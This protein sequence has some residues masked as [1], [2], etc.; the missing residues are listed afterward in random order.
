MRQ[1]IIVRKPG[2]IVAATFATVLLTGASS[3]VLSSGLD[4]A[5]LPISR[6]SGDIN[7]TSN[8]SDTNDLSFLNDIGFERAFSNVLFSIGGMFWAIATFV[9]GI[10]DTIGNTNVWGRIIDDSLKGILRA[11][12]APSTGGVAPIGVL[13]LTALLVA[14]L[15]GV[16]QIRRQGG[17]AMLK[18]V[19]VVAILAGLFWFSSS[20]VLSSDTSESA[21]DYKPPPGTPGWVVKTVADGIDFAAGALVNPITTGMTTP[22]AGDSDDASLLSCNAVLVQMNETYVD[23]GGAA[24]SRAISSMWEMQALPAY[25]GMQF[26]SSNDIGPEVFC[27]QLDYLSSDVDAGMAY[28]ID[29]QIKRDNTLYRPGDG[30]D[31]QG[32]QLGDHLQD[33]QG[34]F[35]GPRYAAY[36]TTTERQWNGTM[37]AWAACDYRG[38][39]ATGTDIWRV[40]PKFVG[41]TGGDGTSEIDDEACRE[42]S[43]LLTLDAASS[44]AGWPGA[45]VWDRSNVDA[46]VDGIADDDP[47]RAEEVRDFLRVLGGD[48][49][50]GN[51]WAYVATTGI[52]STIVGG[53]GLIALVAK[54]ITMF[55][56][57]SIWFL[58]VVSMFRAK[59][60]SEVLGPSLIKL[61]GS[62]L[63]A[64][65]AALIL[66][67]IVMFSVVINTL[68]MLGTN[69]KYTMLGVWVAGISP[70]LAAVAVH[71]FFTKVLKLPSPMSVKGMQ[72]WNRGA[73]FAAGA[74]VG[75][76]AGAGGM[77]LGNRMG[78]AGKGAM[79]SAG[80][81][82][83][84]AAM[85][86][87]GLGG[88]GP[89]ERSG[90]GLGGGRRSASQ[91][92]LLQ[93]DGKGKNTLEQ[94]AAETRK[95]KRQKLR[96]EQQRLRDAGHL[97]DATAFRQQRRQG[98]DGVQSAKRDMAAHK[99][100]LKWLQTNPAAQKQ[101]S[102]NERRRRI[103]QEKLALSN[104]QSA[105]KTTRNDHRS[106]LRQVRIDH[107]RTRW[108]NLR[109]NFQAAKQQTAK[110]LGE[111]PSGFK[112]NVATAARTVR[113]A[114]AG[115]TA[116]QRQRRK[117][118]VRRSAAAGLMVGSLGAAAPMAAGL[119]AP[120]VARAAR[121]K[122]GG[123]QAAMDRALESESKAKAAAAKR[124]PVEEA[125]AEDSGSETTRGEQKDVSGDRTKE[126]PI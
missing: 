21:G 50:I 9:L 42:W 99:R 112:S 87:M 34:A 37:L 94:S 92:E 64:Y 36:N 54:A 49:R 118:V 71:F 95:D 125:K 70:V 24:M 62:T 68:A 113:N 31:G 76:V 108:W 16:Y 3:D 124:A 53:V 58:L 59:P 109:E 101:L 96:Q 15:V 102:A 25:I 30:D 6:W 28:V 67:I 2:L 63:V 83:K 107:G 116:E 35:I 27:R 45:F 74:L 103:A 117:D 10:A 14:I 44:E 4:S 77:M 7:F 88:G 8:P 69:A 110:S 93:G 22:R 79:R 33:A 38:T 104:A 97:K 106:N 89:V 57:I 26:G 75:G 17:M 65:G 18:R 86:R 122:P 82:A 12:V 98:R 85:N 105:Y 11:F 32:S 1:R 78:Q 29:L 5:Y 100:K 91:M 126:G 73:P 39:T 47:A 51:A 90:L 111:K 46:M 13:V 52:S 114:T 80:G 23:E 48:L 72:A 120:D 123:K 55:F 20:Q 41:V 56:L 66:S 40:D 61:L 81:M 119:M 121:G 19:A 115:T 43:E 84:R 60:L